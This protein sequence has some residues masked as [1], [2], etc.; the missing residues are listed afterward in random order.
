[1]IIGIFL[2]GALIF[3]YSFQLNGK[4][5]FYH[6]ITET[7]NK[8]PLSIFYLF[9]LYGFAFIAAVSIVSYFSK[10]TIKPLF[11][12]KFMLFG[13]IAMLLLAFDCSYYIMQFTDG[14]FSDNPYIE[15]WGRASASNISGLVTI[16]IPLYFIYL[17]VKHFKPEW[18]GLRLNGAKVLPYFWLILFMFPLIYLASL[19]P[20]FL[21][22]YPTYTDNF[23][24]KFLEIDQWITAGIYELCYGFDFLSVELFFRGFMVIA[25]SRFV[26]KEAILP[27]VVVYCFLH[28]GK[29]AGEA[30]SSI[31]GG[32][33]LGIL[34]YSSRNIYGG[35]I[36][37]LGVA[38]G[39][40]YMA[41]LQFN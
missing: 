20:D 37:H 14:S 21:E 4:A 1:M 41:Y 31:F 38:W 18:Y 33:I 12:S 10:S 5:D 17:L 15:R 30:V 36:A 40:E 35:L 3:N 23:E 32:Y 8:E 25:L 39:M 6:G 26:G 27:M 24:Y 9:L 11:H 13:T 7:Y 29:P 2:T 19:Q 22:T 16:I 34:A 28:F